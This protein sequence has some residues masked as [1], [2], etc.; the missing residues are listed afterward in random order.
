MSNPTTLAIKAAFSKDWNRL[1]PEHKANLLHYLVDD[2]L[3]TTQYIWAFKT[4]LPHLANLFD[5][6]DEFEQLVGGFADVRKICWDQVKHLMLK[7][8]EWS[9]AGTPINWDAVKEILAG[10]EPMSKVCARFTDKEWC[11]W[12]KIVFDEASEITGRNGEIICDLVDFYD[13]HGGRDPEIR[14]AIRTLSR[15]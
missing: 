1:I 14:E 7:I 8:Q 10:R 15:V 12:A 3:H 6:I 2:T 13:L 4:F 9:V 11:F 5:D